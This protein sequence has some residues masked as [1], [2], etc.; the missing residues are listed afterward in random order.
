MFHRPRGLTPI[1][2]LSAAALLGGVLAPAFAGVAAA[3]SGKPSLDLCVV[4]PGFATG[5]DSFG[6]TTTGPKSF[7]D[8]ATLQASACGSYSSLP[9]TGT[10]TVTQSQTASGWQLAGIYCYSVGS[11]DKAN[12][13]VDLANAAATVKIAGATSCIFAETQG[14]GG[15]GGGSGGGGFSGGSGSS[16]S[17]SGSTT[18]TTTKG[19]TGTTS[20]THKVFIGF[21][22]THPQLCVFKSG[23]VLHQ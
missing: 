8:T 12:G 19:G 17:T 3:A 18:T 11:A 20:T 2:L 13:T 4:E 5:G 6:I 21:C 16:G 15:G 22:A 10:Y 14:S 7:N 23:G 9:A 1:L